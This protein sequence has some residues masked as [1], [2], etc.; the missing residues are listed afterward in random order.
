MIVRF[1]QALE[2]RVSFAP[3]KEVFLDCTP[4]L[5]LKISMVVETD[6]EPDGINKWVQ[7]IPYSGKVLEKNWEQFEPYWT[8]ASEIYHERKQAEE[9]IVREARIITKY[10]GALALARMGCGESFELW[11]KSEERNF[12]EKAFIEIAE[13]WSKKDENF[14]N[15][16]RDLGIEDRMD[17]VMDIGSSIDL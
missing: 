9:A 1:I 7:K 3:E 4:L 5:K 10:Q 16:C 8:K 12:E 13:N 17:E 6:W 11:R 14:R 2:N 15:M